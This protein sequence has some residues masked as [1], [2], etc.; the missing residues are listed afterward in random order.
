MRLG[1]AAVKRSERPERFATA[2]ERSER[3]ETAAERSESGAA[4]LN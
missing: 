2:A 4:E 1:S 3:P